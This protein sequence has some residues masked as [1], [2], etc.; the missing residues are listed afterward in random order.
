MKPVHIILI[1]LLLAAVLFI[2]YYFPLLDRM[3]RPCHYY[4]E[5]FKDCR[6]A[7]R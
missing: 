7:K 2:A 1:C 4:P 5:T 3:V 6:E